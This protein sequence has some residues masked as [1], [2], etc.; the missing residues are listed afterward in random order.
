MKRRSCIATC[1]TSALDMQG[2]CVAADRRT[3][4]WRADFRAGCGS[5]QSACSVNLGLILA[6]YSEER[7]LHLWH[8]LSLQVAGA[9]A[10]PRSILQCIL[11]IVLV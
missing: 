7:L 3:H 8:V 6:T 1:M 9:P 5:L 11:C 2:E 10:H 4:T